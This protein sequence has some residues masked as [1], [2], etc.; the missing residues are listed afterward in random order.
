MNIK[1]IISS[2]FTLALAI[3]LFTACKRHEH[4]E[5]TPD[6]GKTG[7]IE[8]EFDNV[9]GNANFA[10]N[11]TYT[12]SSNEQ[13]K[14]EILKYYISNIKLKTATGTVYTV[15]QDQSYFLVNEAD[16]ASQK[17]KLR[18]PEGDYSEVTF[19]IGVD[20]LRNTMDISK[21][22]GS[23]D[24]AT[25]ASGMYWT[26]NTGYINFKIEG[27]SPASAS[28]FVYHIGGYGGYS[29]VTLN[30]TRTKTLSFG[31]SRANVRAD[32]TGTAVHIT[33]DVLKVFS[34]ATT[35]GIA[36]NP[37]V[38]ATNAVSGNIANNYATMFAFDHVHNH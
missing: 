20:S 16:A 30:N 32:H 29:S 24:P 22:T 18:V 10:L 12:N 11:T 36:A 17:I 33:A 5:T 26:W 2:F 38:M 28:G 14:V 37:M 19:M 23:L 35:V 6:T 1:H 13:F 27:T 31:T 7:E 9:A 34:G 8:L 25:G 15:P 3:T 21:R 4:E